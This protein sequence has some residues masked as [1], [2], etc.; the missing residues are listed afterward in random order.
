MFV[1]GCQQLHRAFINRYVLLE[2]RGILILIN[3]AS[4]CLLGGGT[5]HAWEWHNS[6]Q[7]C[8]HY[9]IFHL[10]EMYLISGSLHNSSAREVVPYGMVAWSTTSN[11]D[12]STTSDSSTGRIDQ[13]QLLAPIAP[14]VRT[15]FLPWPMMW[16]RA[17]SAVENVKD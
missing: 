15:M 4:G 16:G 5:D 14:R 13:K 1:G 9:L 2:S 6:A 17:I 7:L 11:A 8:G 10:T 12:L 3:G